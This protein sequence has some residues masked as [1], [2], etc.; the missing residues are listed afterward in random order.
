MDFGVVGLRLC[1]RFWRDDF[2]F[3]RGQRHGL[4]FVV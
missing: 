1:V 2:M 4:G 3:F